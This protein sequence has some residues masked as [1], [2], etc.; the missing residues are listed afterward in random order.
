PSPAEL[1]QSD[2]QPNF[3][4]IS[5]TDL[6]YVS[7]SPNDIF[8]DQSDGKYY[9]LISGRWYSSSSL[10][11]GWHY[12]ASNALPAN[13]ARIPEGSPKDNVLASVAGTEAARE[14]VMDAQIPQTA[15]VDRNSAHTDV[16]YNGDPQFAPIDGTDMQYGTNTSSSVILENGIYY[17]V[18]NGVWFQA[19]SPS[20]PWTVATE[21]PQE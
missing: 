6:S 2:G 18:D 9:V 1:I 19:P 10:T 5:G 8:K 21:R 20:G 12:V 11:G 13:F 15:K 14:A 7:N 3:T 16:D 17:T 4:S